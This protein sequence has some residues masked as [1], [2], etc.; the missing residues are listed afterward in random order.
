[1]K[2]SA[3]CTRWHA[4]RRRITPSRCP[5]PPCPARRRHVHGMQQHLGHCVLG[6][7]QRGVHTVCA[8]LPRGWHHWQVRARLS[9]PA[10]TSHP[11]APRFIRRRPCRRSRSPRLH[12]HSFTHSLSSAAPLAAGS[13]IHHFFPTLHPICKLSLVVH[14]GRA[15]CALRRWRAG[16][17]RSSSPQACAPAAVSL[18]GG[19]AI[20][21][22][23]SREAAEVRPGEVGGAAPEHGQAWRAGCPMLLRC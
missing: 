14:A 12:T 16:G 9:L 11:H 5:A 1:M 13:N 10:T 4:G 6:V 15:C 8:P 19:A 18:S 2:C 17:L 7:R 3:A 23:P 22:A 21:D 20:G